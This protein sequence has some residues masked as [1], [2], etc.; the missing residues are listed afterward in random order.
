M[1]ILEIKNLH[2]EI[3]GKKILNGLDL[4]IEQGKVHAIM[5]PNG[6]GKSTLG[7]LLCGLYAPDAGNIFIDGLDSRQYSPIYLRSQ[8]RFVG[9]DA[10]LFSGSIKQ[11]LQYC[12]PAAT[13]AELLATL[14]SIGAYRARLLREGEHRLVPVILFEG[15]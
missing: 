9:Q 15:A 4:T 2:A 6:S 12:A 8:F 5:G 11:N 3:E 13:D 10:V 14:Q 7:R 1:P